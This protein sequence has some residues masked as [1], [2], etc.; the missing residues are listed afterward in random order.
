MSATTLL[1]VAPRFCGPPGSANGGYFAGLVAAL[2]PVPVRVRLRRPPPLATA[3][4]AE[5]S[6]DGCIVVRHGDAVVAE[7]RPD[8]P[9][10]EVPPAVPR[11]AAIEASL[12]YRG[13]R[14]HVFPR[15]FVCGPLR[16]RGDGLRLFTGEVAGRTEPGLVASPWNPD[17]SL[18]LGDGRIAPQFIWAALDCPGYFA[19]APDGR[20]A[21][22]AEHVAR[23]ERRPRIDEPMVAIGWRIGGEGRVHE[24]GTALFG[25][26]GELVASAQATWIEPRRE[27]VGG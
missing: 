21:L 13:L 18:A 12:R 10:L 16:A 9:R 15:C 5:V 26:D 4:P 11:S 6:D 25:E 20:V 2:S 24:A 1:T 14:Q 22:L 17:A 23:I 27:P 19:I 3:L 7:A 8:L